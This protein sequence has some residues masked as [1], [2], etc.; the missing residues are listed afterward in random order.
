MAKPEGKRGSW[1]AKWK[2]EEY[3]CVHRCW[4]KGN[5]PRYLDPGMDDNPK[6][7]PYVES[8]KLG[9]AILT[10][11]ELDEAGNPINRTGYVGLYRVENVE[12][13]DKELH[14]EFKEW[15]LPSRSR[16]SVQAGDP[17]KCPCPAL[18]SRSA[19]MRKRWPCCAFLRL[20]CFCTTPF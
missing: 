19:R 8:L 17:A 11:D 13:R 4:T 12:V 20:A 15:H 3:P 10:E 16:G 7:G 1:F 6:W 18:W 2:G 5:W 9:H 14:F